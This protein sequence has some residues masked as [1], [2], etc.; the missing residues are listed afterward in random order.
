MGEEFA[1]SLEGLSDAA[2]A[3]LTS[4][5]TVKERLLMPYTSVTQMQP[6][7]CKVSPA[8]GGTAEL[9]AFHVLHALVPCTA[10]KC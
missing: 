2:L 10:S 4:G 5:G 3:Q 9:Y 8:A 1:S 6:V 7:G